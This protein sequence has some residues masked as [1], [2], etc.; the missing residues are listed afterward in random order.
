MAEFSCWGQNKF[1]LWNFSRKH[2]PKQFLLKKIILEVDFKNTPWY[3]ESALRERATQAKNKKQKKLKKS[4]QNLLAY[5]N[6]KV[7]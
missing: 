1:Y 4:L 2:P 5:G 7:P 6:I 3:N